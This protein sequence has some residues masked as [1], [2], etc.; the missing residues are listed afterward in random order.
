MDYLKRNS[1]LELLRFVFMLCVVVGHVYSHGTDCDFEHL[2][3]FRNQLGTL[4]HY[5]VWSC[6]QIG[7]V[8]FMIIS[9]YMGMKLNV[10]KLLI[11]FATIWFYAIVFLIIDKG[12]Y[13]II[14]AL[15]YTRRW[16]FVYCYLVVAI[17]GSLFEPAMQYV[18][19]RNWTLIIVALILYVGCYQLYVEDSAHSAGTLLTLYL[20]GR[21]IRRYPPPVFRKPFWS[22]CNNINC[23]VFVNHAYYSL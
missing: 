4:H 23:F 19:K 15:K 21:Y 20:I 5:I 11:L 8:G 14:H 1:S 13:N 16:W 3:S 7:V 2:F 17:I 10:R 9:G 22:Y 12:D 6:A 18:S